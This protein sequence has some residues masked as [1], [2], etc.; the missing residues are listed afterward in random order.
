MARFAIGERDF[1]LDGEPHRVLA[2]ALHYFRVHPDQWADRIEKARRMGLNA[3]ETYVAWNAHEPVRG[4]F[5]TDGALDLDRFLRLIGEAGMHA[6]VRPGPYICA[7]WDSGGLPAWLFR[8]PGIRL[9]SAEPGWLA[10]IDAY[11]DHVLP[12]VAPLQID[13]GGPV[14]LLQVENEYGAY[15][16]DTAYLEHLV[17]RYRGG[18]ITVPLTTV[19]Q[20][21]DDMLER[22]R[23]DGA[24]LTGSFGS[25]VPERLATLRQHQPTGP[26]M[27]SEFWDGWFDHWGEHHH[28]TSA[29]D[30]AASL[31]E[32]L[33]AGASVSIYMFHGGTDFGFTNGANHKGAYKS[34]VTSYDYDAPLDETG[35]ATPKF[36]AFRDVI[37]RYAP[38]PEEDV[39][40]APA[41]PAL[42]AAFDRTVALSAVADRLGEELGPFDAPPAFDDVEH[43]RGFGI[44]AAPLDGRSGV[45]VVG[46]VRDRAQVLVDGVPVGVLE[47]DRHD[48]AL[49]IPAGRRLELL[50]EDRGRVNYGD[51]LG[52][53]KGLLG[54][55]T[56]DGLPVTGWTVRPLRL[57]RL[58]AADLGDAAG[59]D[60]GAAFSIA[61]FDLDA[62]AD[63]HL[64]TTHWGKGVAWVNGFHLGRYWARGPQHTLFVPG[65]QLVAGTNELVVLELHGFRDPAVRFVPRPLLGQ[66]EE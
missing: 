53:P 55:V 11:L 19:D 12:I 64:D 21:T 48:H 29:E 50:V 22:G 47:R 62:P 5:A 7:E 24:L 23:V 34:H 61:S 27:C 63:L 49:R 51:R 52:E 58:T 6:I 66:V 32:L 46:A 54:P 30:A 4:S 45:L 39:P 59:T 43:P 25:R 9:R 38:V 17:R 2:G 3:I 15:G 31:D 28:T 16:D 10:E 41:A 18:G 57:D 20:P 26:L 56:L 14:I 44:Y 36:R 42:T 8:R 35:W 33:A 40:T 65:T 60:A 1:L 37:R 13:R